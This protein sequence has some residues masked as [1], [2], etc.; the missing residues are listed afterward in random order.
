MLGDAAGEE[1]A[2]D[3][4]GADDEHDVEALHGVAAVV[5]GELVQIHRGRDEHADDGEAVEGLEADGKGGVG[6]KRE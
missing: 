4:E 5:G 3:G 1:V 2:E 6:E